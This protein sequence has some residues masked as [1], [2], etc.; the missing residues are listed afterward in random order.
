MRR[1]TVLHELAAATGA[2]A[3]GAAVGGEQAFASRLPGRPTVTPADLR[4]PARKLRRGNAS[5][6]GLVKS[7]VDRIVP[8][9]AAFMDGEAPSHPGFV[10][11]ISWAFA[12]LSVVS[13]SPT[14]RIWV[15]TW[16]RNGRGSSR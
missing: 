15:L 16:S 2:T 7:H 5:E 3:L 13:T 4:F 10:V 8:G 6:A 9:A 12:T 1:R 14:T 11:L